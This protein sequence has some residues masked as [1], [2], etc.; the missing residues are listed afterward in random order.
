MS[1]GPRWV[2]RESGVRVLSFDATIRALRAFAGM[3]TVL[4][5][6]LMDILGDEK[7]RLYE[8]PPVLVEHFCARRNYCS[9]LDIARVAKW[10]VDINSRYK[11]RLDGTE[12]LAA[13][14][15]GSDDKGLLL[16]A[17][18][19]RT[20]RGSLVASH[21]QELEEAA[22]KF[23]E[24]LVGKQLVTSKALLIAL[25]GLVAGPAPHPREWSQEAQLEVE[26]EFRRATK[27]FWIEL[28]VGTV[29]DFGQ[30]L[31]R[32]FLDDPSGPTGDGLCDRLR[33]EAVFA[34]TRQMK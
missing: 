30:G 4:R 7:V 6:E 24:Q 23:A 22:A 26:R 19:E 13:V 18:E 12:E 16:P 25:G 8:V 34:F 9:A 3:A 2:S 20:V 27:L 32:E 31:D 1:P 17:E 11:E 15:I 21:L 14:G 33:D 29:G 5:A 10:C 28:G